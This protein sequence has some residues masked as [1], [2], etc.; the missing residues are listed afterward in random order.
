MKKQFLAL[1]AVAVAMPMLTP[2]LSAQTNSGDRRYEGNDTRYPC[3]KS[4]GTTGTVAGAVGGGLVGHALGGGTLG[5]VA[6]A[7]GGALL[8]R[9]L[10]KKHDEAQNRKNGC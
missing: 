6:G 4:S 5:T 7:G 1:A 9:H 10:D 3:K 8:G 2:P